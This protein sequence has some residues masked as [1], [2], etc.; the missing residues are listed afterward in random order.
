[1]LGLLSAVSVCICA[2]Q[3]QN[4]Q[5]TD[6]VQVCLSVQ[7]RG[8]IRRTRTVHQNKGSCGHFHFIHS[9][10]LYPTILEIFGPKEVIYAH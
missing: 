3:T 5:T 4:L 7:C 8:I 2:L 6:W 10:P 9:L 1:M